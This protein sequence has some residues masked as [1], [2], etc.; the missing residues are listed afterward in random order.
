MHFRRR[1][2]LTYPIPSFHSFQLYGSA[3]LTDS[4]GKERGAF[5]KTVFINPERCVGCKQCEAAC[6]VEHS[7]SKNL[8]LSVLESPKPKPRIHSDPGLT[9]D[10][11]FPNK[12]RH[13]TPAPCH[14]ACPT[15]AIHR[16]GDFPDIV[17]VDG[18]KCIACLMCAMVCPFDVITAFPSAAAPQRKAVA[19]KCDDCIDRQVQGR[20]PACVEACKS[21]ALM[22]G[23]FNELVKTART[24]YSGAVSSHVAQTRDEIL[25]LPPSLES[26]RKLGTVVSVIN[27]SSRKGE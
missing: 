17:L 13:C 18:K 25:G 15:G 14:S 3:V 16:S 12:C 4:G 19:T 8:F 10:T 20:I 23:E 5:M 2:N 21:E 26:M 7:Q 1:G 24:E 6:A 9:M 11:S 22:F 27:R